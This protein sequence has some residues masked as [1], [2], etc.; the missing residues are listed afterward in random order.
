MNELIERFKSESP[1]FFKKLKK[2]S[3]SIGTSFAAIIAANSAMGLNLNAT[4]IT[5]LGYIVAACVA[6]AGT[7][8]LTKQ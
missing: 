4:F 3:I 7:A 1:V 8:Q 6:I 5:I 2:V